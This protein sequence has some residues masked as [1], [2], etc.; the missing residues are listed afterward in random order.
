M[1]NQWSSGLFDCGE[2]SVVDT[3]QPD[4]DKD[5]SSEFARYQDN[6][7]PSDSPFSLSDLRN[8]IPAHCFVRSYI[9]SFAYLSLDLALVYIVYRTSN[10]IDSIS[11]SVFQTL[12]WAL[13]G[14]IQGSLCFAVWVIAHECGH[15][16]FSRNNFVNDS[17]GLVLHSILLVPYFS[18]KYM[19]AK[20]HRNTNRMEGDEVFLPRTKSES[21]SDYQLWFTGPGRLFKIV[22]LL[23]FGWI[24]HLWVHETGQHYPRWTSHFNPYAPC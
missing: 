24:I 15:G 1:S 18:W 3:F 7:L 10:F 16:G 13:Y 22:V 4:N 11:S 8:S 23:S 17:V 9:K 20:H 6:V 5:V 14:W 12:L 2:S 21:E 19:H